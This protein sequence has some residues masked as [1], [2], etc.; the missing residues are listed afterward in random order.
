MIN[1]IPVVSVIIAT[2]NRSDAVVE[3]VKSVLSQTYTSIEVIVVDDGSTDDTVSLLRQKFGSSIRIIELKQ[4]KGATYARNEGIRN[5]TGAYV[6][7]WDSDDLL[8][9]NAVQCLVEKA[10]EYQDVCTVSAAT[11]VF[12]NNIP[13]SFE[14]IPE[15]YLDPVTIICAQMP[16][17][18][19]VRMVKRGAHE[20]IL[21][22]GK[23]LDFMVNNELV[24]YGPWYHLNQE[25][26]DHFLFSDQHS[27]TVHRRKLSAASSIM[28]SD[29][30]FE[31]I[32]QFKDTY[33]HN[34]PR[35]YADYAY[36]ATLG[37]ILAGNKKKARFVARE[38]WKFNKT[39]KHL[40]LVGIAFFPL[41]NWL[42][43]IFYR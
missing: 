35:R 14:K 25:L 21:Y 1:Q 32:Q 31:H 16:K 27:L 43:R 15:G 23:N 17:Y 36:G 33:I 39:I 11:K 26:G 41:N 10:Q 18:K 30:I 28:R 38:A 19:L 34:C 37:F 3:S 7:V 29:I 8:Y 22:R 4:N 24:T 6:I 12:K 2:F 20:K 40:F 13:I 5:A 42:L 9:P